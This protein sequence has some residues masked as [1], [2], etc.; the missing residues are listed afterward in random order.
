VLGT[1]GEAGLAVIVRQ[2][3]FAGTRFFSVSSA[4]YAAEFAT[5]PEMTEKACMPWA[6][7]HSL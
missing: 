3:P 1:Q 6:K 5:L 7:W 2:P 4:C